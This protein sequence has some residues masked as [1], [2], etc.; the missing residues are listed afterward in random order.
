MFRPRS[1]GPRVRVEEVSGRKLK[2][3]RTY[4]TNWE[5]V[6]SGENVLPKYILL[7]RTEYSQH[8]T[9]L[10]NFVRFVDFLTHCTTSKSCA[11]DDNNKMR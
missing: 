4:L 5:P 1:D 2:T 6:T 10:F 9:N 8:I 7:S 11:I 3:T